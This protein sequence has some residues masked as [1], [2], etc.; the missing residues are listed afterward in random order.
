MK[1]ETA[2]NHL[3]VEARR[4]CRPDKRDAVDVGSIETGG[5]NV[6][7][8]KILQLTGFEPGQRCVPLWD[9]CFTTHE[10]TLD[11]MF[12]RQDLHDV[13]TVL[14]A[15]GKDQACLPLHRV[16]HNLGGS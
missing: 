4:H 12:L 6:D 14:D 16:L 5:Q 1:A 15:G 7:V 2:A 13:L 8:A 10:T 11:A 3:V 9:R